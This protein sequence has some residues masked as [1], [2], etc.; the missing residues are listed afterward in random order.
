MALVSERL[1]WCGRVWTSMM[2]SP[3]SALWYAFFYH[4]PLLLSLPHLCIYYLYSMYLYMCILC[5]YTHISQA[6]ELL[7]EISIAGITLTSGIP[8]PPVSSPLLS[9]RSDAHICLPGNAPLKHTLWNAEE[10]LRIAGRQDLPRYSS[11]SQ[12]PAVHLLV[13]I[14]SV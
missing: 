7:G 4:S 10:L 12:Q 1:D 6:L 13:Y 9:T 3:L 14:Y 8:F 2:T 5:V 11:A